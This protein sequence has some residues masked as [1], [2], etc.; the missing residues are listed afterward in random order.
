MKTIFLIL[1]VAGAAVVSCQAAEVNS[2]SNDAK[3][4][5]SS[6]EY[7]AVETTVS[8]PGD[9]R[10]QF[11]EFKQEGW[12]I[13][14][15]CRQKTNENGAVVWRWE[16]SRPPIP[17]PAPVDFAR[18]DRHVKIVGDSTEDLRKQLAQWQRDGWA[19]HNISR[20]VTN[21]DGRVTRALNMSRP[22]AASAA[23]R[24]ACVCNLYLLRAA[25]RQWALDNGKSIMDR[26]ALADLERYFRNH[27]R[28]PSCPSGGSYSVG[29]VWDLPKCSVP[30]HRLMQ[31]YEEWKAEHE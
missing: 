20:A 12:N 25:I 3:N 11:A 21:D 2:T 9:L 31:S 10:K 18:E 27:D 24:D 17:D 23:H 30:G 1:I 6:R 4:S 28:F 22:Q 29:T 8:S 7:R 13:H 5:E 14:S 15:F 26:V 16:V 19:I